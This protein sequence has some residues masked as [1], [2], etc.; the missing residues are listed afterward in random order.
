MITIVLLGVLVWDDVRIITDGLT[1]NPHEFDLP[2]G[3]PG[4]TQKVCTRMCLAKDPHQCYTCSVSG[5]LIISCI[6][7]LA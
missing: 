2:C 4:W 5:Y 7:L 3:L 6:L 1:S